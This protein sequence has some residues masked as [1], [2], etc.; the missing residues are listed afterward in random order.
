MLNMDL[1][2]LLPKKETE[3]IE[4]YWSVII[5]PGWL[6][7]GIWK[8]ENKEAVVFYSG[9]PLSWESDEDLI[10]TADTAVSTALAGFPED[11]EEPS[12]TVFGLISS[13]VEGGQI[14]DEYLQKIKRICSE[15]S[16]KPVGFVVLSEAISHFIKSQEGSPLNSVVVGVYSENI[17]ISVFQMGNLVGNTRVARSVSIVDDLAEGLSRFS[18]AIGLPSRFILYNG[19][20]GELEEARQQIFK[21]NWED[22]PNLKF[23]HTPKVEIITSENK[24]NAVTL[25]GA[26]EISEIN[27]VKSDEQDALSVEDTDGQIS[28]IDRNVEEI[29]SDEITPEDVGFVVDT[30]GDADPIKGLPEFD[31]PEVLEKQQTE[32]NEFHDGGKKKLA[33]SK[34]AFLKTAAKPF[35]QKFK[36]FKK[37]SITNRFIRT[38]LFWGPGIILSLIVIVFVWWWF[39]NQAEVTIYVS[40]RP[41]SE[42]FT[43][44]IGFQGDGDLNAKIIDGEFSGEK[45]VSVTGTK[46]IGDKAKGEIV[47]YRAGS[48]I[49][50][51]SETQIT[52]T[53]GLKYEL[54]SDVTVASGSA[55]TPSTT[56]VNVTAAD[57]GSEYNISSGMVFQIGNYST[58][59]V[60]AK[61]ENS[62]SGGSSRE[63]S[64]VS[65]DDKKDLFDSLKNGLFKQAED[66]LKSKVTSEEILIVQSFEDSIIAEDY[67][68]KVGDEASNL[69][70][71][72]KLKV[73]ALVLLKDELQSY[74]Y[75][76]FETKIPSGF[77]LKNENIKTEFKFSEKAEGKYVFDI[78]AVAN[79]LPNID[80]E[81]VKSQILGKYV[82]LAQLHLKNTIPSIS[83]SEVKL[84]YRFPGRLRSLPRY[85]KNLTISIS[86]EK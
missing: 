81:D 56:K 52:A 58:G 70:L 50:I 22:Y 38:P 28:D 19:R 75:K 64:V 11:H 3:E 47:I 2:S 32:I 12:K 42:N 76:Y 37:P 79:L 59:D 8:T 65:A 9:T 77:V 63:A 33:N 48:E 21:A 69:K 10:N 55:S 44:T 17:E 46:L 71:N 43:V 82:P 78:Y 34:I 20:E 13:W 24:N 53:N 36:K 57:I 25:A 40:S 83:S 51:P 18:E 15:L 14:K 23:L 85:S 49:K 61:N 67:D 73:S 60:E 41:L 45:T 7:A 26:S 29:S 66:D 16:L 31:Q 6:Q 74:S 30:Q 5:E 54:D 35:A 80:V 72:L 68:A 86:A 27:S 84:K 39:F 4:Y 1:K 62:F